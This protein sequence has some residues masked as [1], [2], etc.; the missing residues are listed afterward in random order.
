MYSFYLGLDLYLKKTYAVLLDAQGDTL[1]ERHIVN[2]GLPTYL[3]EVV[4]PS[5]YA[6]L[7]ATRNW[8]FL[9]N[10]LVE[11]VERGELAHP[12]ELKAISSAAV[13]TDRIDA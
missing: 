12:K 13:K 9:Y 3:H 2:E 10:L 5:T 6:V 7:E 11:H 8:P 4:P 1:D